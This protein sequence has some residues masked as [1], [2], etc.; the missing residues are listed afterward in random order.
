MKQPKQIY[1]E[2]YDWCNSE[3][4]RLRGLMPQRVRSA[5]DRTFHNARIYQLQATAGYFIGLHDKAPD[6][7]PGTVKKLDQAFHNGVVWARSTRDHGVYSDHVAEA[8]IKPILDKLRAEAQ[9]VHPPMPTPNTETPEPVM[10]IEKTPTEKLISQVLTALT[11]LEDIRKADPEAYAMAMHQRAETRVRARTEALVAAHTAISVLLASG[12][13]Y[14]P[15]ETRKLAD[16]V[17]R[18]ELEIVAAFIE[19]RNPHPLKSL[20]PEA[21]R[22]ENEGSP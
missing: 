4:D 18:E 17:W 14:F 8:N 21:A 12:F 15:E 2:V 20:S 5:A 1:R 13:H 6:V 10:T 11:E 19:S 22:K 9:P 3:V 16:E 7:D